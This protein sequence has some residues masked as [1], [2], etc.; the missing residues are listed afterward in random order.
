MLKNHIVQILMQVFWIPS[1]RVIEWLLMLLLYFIHIGQQRIDC[2]KKR[3]QLRP[4]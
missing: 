3:K 4:Q 2:S 1:Y